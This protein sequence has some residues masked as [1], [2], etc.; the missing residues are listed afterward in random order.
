MTDRTPRSL[1][2]RHLLRVTAAGASLAGLARAGGE[3]PPAPP[4][5]SDSSSMIGVPFAKHDRVRFGLVGR[6]R[7]LLRPFPDFT[8]GG[9]SEERG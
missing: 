6:G 3:V 2:R 1:S 5:P 8:R 9:W 4:R 7:S